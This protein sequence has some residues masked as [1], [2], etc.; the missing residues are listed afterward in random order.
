MLF[1]LAMS[2]FIRCIKII[3]RKNMQSN[4][5][6]VSLFADKSK[7]NYDDIDAIY[8]QLMV[9]A[10]VKLSDTD[11]AIA[12]SSKENYAALLKFSERLDVFNVNDRIGRLINQNV[13]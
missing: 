12:A 4:R 11:E 3:R 7:L 1:N 9:E 5:E 8:T 2:S 10:G 6:E 13:T